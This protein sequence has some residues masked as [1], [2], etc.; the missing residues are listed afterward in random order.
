[1][2]DRLANALEKLVEEGRDM[3][4]VAEMPEQ[5]CAKNQVN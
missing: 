3:K 4:K 1:M 5:S 2:A